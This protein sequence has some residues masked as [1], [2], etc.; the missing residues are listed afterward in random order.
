M[1]TRELLFHLYPRMF[2]VHDLA[3]DVAIP[4][5]RGWIP[6]PTFMRPS[7]LHMEGHGAYLIGNFS[8]TSLM[9]ASNQSIEHRQRRTDGPLAWWSCITEDN[10]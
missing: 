5:E 1:G 7:Y 2:A 10:Q 3:Y 8:T 4:D 9:G 6:L